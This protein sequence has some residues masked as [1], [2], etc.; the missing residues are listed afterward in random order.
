[1]S[2]AHFQDGAWNFGFS[3]A[4]TYITT[5]KDLIENHLGVLTKPHDL[6]VSVPCL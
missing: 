5:Q 3:W 4:E 2:W 6:G 1:M